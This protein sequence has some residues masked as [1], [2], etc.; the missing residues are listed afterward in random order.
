[1]DGCFLHACVFVGYPQLVVDLCAVRVELEVHEA[2]S[3]AGIEVA[4]DVVFIGKVLNRV[5]VE[6]V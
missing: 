6:G 2:T 5:D 1:M 3:D 4:F